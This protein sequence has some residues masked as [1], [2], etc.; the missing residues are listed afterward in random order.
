MYSISAT[1]QSSKTVLCK[2]CSQNTKCCTL[3]S[4]VNE[5][6]TNNGGCA[7]ACT[8]TGG[9]YFCTCNAGYSLA[10]DARSCSGKHG[11]TLGGDNFVI[12]E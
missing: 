7:Q 11:V 8:N 10:A 5:C 4:D 2:N 3:I 12:L 9:S 6:L 1:F